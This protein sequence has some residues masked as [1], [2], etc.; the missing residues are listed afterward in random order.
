MF[1][2]RFFKHYIAQIIKKL[3]ALD[4]TTTMAKM[5]KVCH[6]HIAIADNL[7]KMGLPG[8]KAVSEVWKQYPYQPIP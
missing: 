8:S 1:N 6:T 5:L 4:L 2:S 3:L 7:N